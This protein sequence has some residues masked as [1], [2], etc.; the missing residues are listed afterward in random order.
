[1]RCRSYP[2]FPHFAEPDTRYMTHPHSYGDTVVGMIFI[3]DDSLW[4]SKHSN[5][6]VPERNRHRIRGVHR[7]KEGSTAFIMPAVSATDTL[8]FGNSNE[9]LLYTFS[10]TVFVKFVARFRKFKL[11]IFRKTACI[12]LLYLSEGHHVLRLPQ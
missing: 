4:E 1:M 6:I 12:I 3:G 10:K 5:S 11:H 2:R 9:I 8:E 7:A